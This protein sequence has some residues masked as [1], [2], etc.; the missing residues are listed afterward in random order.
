MLCVLLLEKP[1][2]S[3]GLYPGQVLPAHQ[4]FKERAEHAITGCSRNRAFALS[5]TC[6]PQEP[7]KYRPKNG[8]GENP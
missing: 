7:L 4:P 8:I 5:E 2:S 3:A 1:S 6:V